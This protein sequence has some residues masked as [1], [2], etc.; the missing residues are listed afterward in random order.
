MAR[1]SALFQLPT[2]VAASA[3]AAAGAADAASRKRPADAAADGTAAKAPKVGSPG[4][5]LYRKAAVLCLCF[6]KAMCRAVHVAPCMP[7]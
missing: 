1:H 4:H 7:L 6:V 5:L 3:S 2:S